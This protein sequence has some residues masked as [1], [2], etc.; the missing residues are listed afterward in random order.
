MPGFQIVKFPGGELISVRFN[1]KS[2][3]FEE[4]RK[5]IEAHQD[6]P[7]DIAI[8]VYYWQVLEQSGMA[9]FFQRAKL[10]ASSS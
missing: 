6:E 10:H 4:D 2:E 8:S 5:W 1:T 9:Y 7:L 3:S